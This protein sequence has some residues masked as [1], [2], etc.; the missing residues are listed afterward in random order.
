MYPIP[1][2]PVADPFIIQDVQSLPTL[3]LGQSGS[4]FAAACQLCVIAQEVNMVYHEKS[5]I[6]I[7][8]RVPFSFVESKYSEAEGNHS[9]SH[10][11]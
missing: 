4:L 2:L 1:G 5:D 6:P 9:R 7:A 3:P 11:T 8:Q 10:R